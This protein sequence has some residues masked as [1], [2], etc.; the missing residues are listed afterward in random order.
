MLFEGAALRG[1]D[2]VGIGI[3]D[4]DGGVNSITKFL[5]PY[6]GNDELILDYVCERMRVGSVLLA[7]FRAT[8]ETEPV[9]DYPMIQPLNLPSE[10]LFLI[11]N[12]GVTDSVKNELSFDFQTPL[13][14][15]AIIASYLAN[16]KNMV[17]TM[18]DLSGSF[19]FVLL[20]K[21]KDKLFAV[22]SF[23]PLAHSYVRGYGYF[24]HSDNETLGK[25]LYYL[26]QSTRDGINVW[27]S[28]YHHDL[29]GYSIYET[30]LQSGF[31]T[32][33]KF[34]PRF[35]HPKWDSL[36]EPGFHQKTF[37]VASGGIDSG[38]TAFLLMKGGHD[39][40]MLHFDYGQKSEKCEAWAIN[41]LS[42]EWGIGYHTIDLKHIYHSLADPSML[43]EQ[44]IPVTSGGDDIKS[45]IAWVAGRNAI[46]ASIAMAYAE[47]A[48]LNYNYRH[49]Y[50]SA[51]WSQLSEETGGY[52]D[53]S[54]KFNKAVDMLKR[55]GYITGHRISFMPV[56]Q[57]LTKTECWRLGDAFN[58]PFEFTVSCDA[59]EM[60]DGRPHLCTDCG[61]TKLSMIAADRSGA[62][63][64][65]RFK[66][67]AGYGARKPENLPTVLTA[68]QDIINRLYID[69]NARR[70]LQDLL[71]G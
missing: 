10:G 50:L 42:H 37:V 21:A 30:D 36:A 2:G 14:S 38:L 16:G 27:E 25:V 55:Y 8:P 69:H 70:Q 49:V 54:Y 6:E 32:K 20:D 26:V 33:Q 29:E 53:N 24:Y 34:K 5:G 52:P 15:E 48:I 19:A 60:Y 45:T 66:G 22:T 43:L 17:A 62:I 68:P 58:F 7:S 11:H 46:F 12:G 39:V 67:S 41:K 65:R 35:L 59:P 4:P 47:S 56:L 23:L 64:N 71:R 13:D 61:S 40:S 1:Q 57:N 9:T 3:I 63:D 28:W 44:N 31:Q 18:E 51:G